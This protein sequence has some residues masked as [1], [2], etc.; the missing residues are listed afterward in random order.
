VSVDVCT[1]RQQSPPVSTTLDQATRSTGVM[2]STFRYSVGRA[3]FLAKIFLYAMNL[4]CYFI[5]HRV[6]CTDVNIMHGYHLS[7]MKGSHGVHRYQ[8][9]SS[10]NVRVM[11]TRDNACNIPGT[12]TEQWQTRNE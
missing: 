3:A 5:L 12:A 9:L 8:K 7:T 11:L 6:K 10:R 2:S 1:H 4:Y